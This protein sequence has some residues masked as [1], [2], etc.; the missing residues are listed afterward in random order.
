MSNHFNVYFLALMIALGSLLSGSVSA[1]P[2]S[3]DIP[4]TPEHK[5]A[6]YLSELGSFESISFDRATPYS[7]L[8]QHP[9]LPDGLL[10]SLDLKGAQ[11]GDA[12]MVMQGKTLLAESSVKV[13]YQNLVTLNDNGLLEGIEKD[14]LPSIVNYTPEDYDVDELEVGSGA[15]SYQSLLLLGLFSIFRQKIS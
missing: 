9:N 13:P 2:T 15:V 10:I 14:A 11:V 7:Q 1:S 8:D 5:A 12:F 4:Q 6:I 3:N